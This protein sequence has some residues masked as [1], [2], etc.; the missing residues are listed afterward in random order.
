MLAR[1]SMSVLR[2]IPRLPP[3]GG[4]RRL[5]VT[6]GCPLASQSAGPEPRRSFLSVVP[7]LLCVWYFL[8][9][10]GRPPAHPRGYPRNTFGVP[11]GYPRGP[12]G[13]PQRHTGVSPEQHAGPASNNKFTRTL[14]VT[15][16]QNDVQFVT[17][18]LAAGGFRKNRFALH[19]S[20]PPPCF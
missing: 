18:C 13:Y 9:T 20:L 6:P 4:R 11:P 8:G 3:G 2:R 5:E 10:P 7:C 12:P 17:G 16:I 1:R 15:L 14:W 19:P